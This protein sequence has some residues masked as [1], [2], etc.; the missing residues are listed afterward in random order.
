M[1]KKA[2][3]RIEQILETSS[4]SETHDEKRQIDIE[5]AQQLAAA[6]VPGSVEEKALVRKLDWRLVV[7]TS[8][9]TLLS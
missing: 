3:G 4:S 7:C 9:V 8:L 1:D 6:Y 2:E 5:H